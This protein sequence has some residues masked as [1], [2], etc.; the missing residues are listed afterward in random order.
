MRSSPCLRSRRSTRS[1]YS[2]SAL[3]T[4][5][6]L[7]PLPA[8]D[9]PQASLVT[10]FGTAVGGGV[11][12]AVV[13]SLPATIRV[14]DDGSVARA[15]TEWL[16]LAATATPFA[17]AAVA[18]L[19]RARVG[20]K[21]LVGTRADAW[22]AGFFAWATFQ[23]LFA[24]AFG[25]LLRKHTH[26]HGLAGVT[27][28]IAAAGFG[29]VLAVLVVRVMKALARLGRRVRR[30]AA[31]V[32]ALATFIVL[33]VAAVRTAHA[34]GLHTTAG[35]VDALAFVLACGAASSRVVAR[36]KPLAIAGVPVAAIVVALGLASLN[37][38]SALRG[39]FAN[40]APL[41]DMFLSMFSR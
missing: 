39:A 27:F 3:D 30:S 17:I 13:A 11:I 8:D 9:D 6:T 22:I 23:M 16:A 36:Q 20:A 38:D 33:V 41:H 1:S 26:H 28:A 35:I 18:I 31:I 24:T 2:A 4:Q 29:L 25:S 14:G 40:D 7:E 5:P 12:A 34:E 21:I 19:R 10:R 32:A 37:G 15:S